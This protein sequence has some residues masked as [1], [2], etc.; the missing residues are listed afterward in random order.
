MPDKSLNTP[1]EIKWN[2]VSVKE[3]REL[4]RRAEKSN[5]LQSWPYAQAALVTE[6]LVG[7]FATI[8]YDNRIVGICQVLEQRLLKVFHKVRLYRGPLWLEDN[9]PEH[10]QEIF[11]QEIR[12]KYP[13]RL[14]RFTYF[15]P[16][17][18]DSKENRNVLLKSGLKRIDTDGYA[19]IW[20]DLTKSE[21]DLKANLKSNWR[22]QLNQ[23]YKKGLSLEVDTKGDHLNWLLARNEMDKQL[24]EFRG[25]SPALVGNL[26]RFTKDRN[27]FLLL[28]AIE[29]A[30]PVAAVLVILHEASATYLIGWNSLEGRKSRAHNYLIWN[31]ILELKK[32]NIKWLDLGGINPKEAAGVTAFKRGIGGKEFTLTGSYN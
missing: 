20:L 22:N 14:W 23:S 19:S 4:V 28:R 32:R 2:C 16:E 5:L 17:T 24:K 1:V 29:K 3:W 13:S 12:K 15:L 7:K 18:A 8:H 25:P 10:V 6:R 26:K 9:L 21:N 27:D 31:M 30:T 11:W